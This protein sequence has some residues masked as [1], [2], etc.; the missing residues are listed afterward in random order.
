MI[1]NKLM[2]EYKVSINHQKFNLYTISSVNLDSF[3]CM[4]VF[5]V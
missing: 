2:E 1:L 5:S 3:L 4:Y